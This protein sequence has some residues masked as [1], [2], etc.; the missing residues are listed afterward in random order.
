MWNLIK[1]KNIQMNV[2]T[3]RNRLT[4]LENKLRVYRVEGLIKGRDR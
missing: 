3:I 2:C 1:R 4:Y